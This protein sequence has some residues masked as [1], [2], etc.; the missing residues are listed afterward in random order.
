MGRVECKG[1]FNPVPR[2]VKGR[3]EVFLARLA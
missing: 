3:A 1:V 2:I